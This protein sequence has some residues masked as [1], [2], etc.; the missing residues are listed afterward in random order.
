MNN[1]T[2]VIFFSSL[3][4]RSTD[5]ANESFVRCCFVFFKETN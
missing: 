3:S 1:A 2:K 5:L 4:K